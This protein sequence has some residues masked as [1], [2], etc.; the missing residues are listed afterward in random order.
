MNHQSV[1]TLSLLSLVIGCSD[2]NVA[3]EST[4]SNYSGVKKPGA[5]D[6]KQKSTSQRPGSENV[7]KSGTNTEKESF[8]VTQTAGKIDIVWIVDQSGSMQKETANVQKNLKDFISKVDSKIDA[9]HAL[10]ASRTNGFELD[11]DKLGIASDKVKQI[12]RYVASND[13]LIIAASAFTRSGAPRPAGVSASYEAIQGSLFDFFRPGVRPI[14][15][16]VTDDNAVGVNE[17]NFMQIVED[18]NN[19]IGIRPLVYSFAG[20]VEPAEVP[21]DLRATC[22]IARKGTAYLALAELSTPKAVV[23]DICQQDWTENFKKLTEGVFVAAQNSFRLKKP[24]SKILKVLVNGK[25]ADASIFT[26]TSGVLTI[27][28]EAINALPEGNIRVDVE[29]KP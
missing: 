20:R 19:S 27:L 9:R 24:A 22:D 11:I 21:Q 18:K 16:V 4:R 28:P 29:Y 23:F 15:V 17:T 26:Y 13:A 2:D 1:L 12:D 14:V 10:I 6:I 3:F 25:A 5:E 8:S 7:S